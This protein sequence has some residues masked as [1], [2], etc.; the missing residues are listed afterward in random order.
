MVL[1]ILNMHE[2]LNLDAFVMPQCYNTGVAI[3][4]DTCILTVKNSLKVSYH[5]LLV[6]VQNFL[7]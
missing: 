4:K 6:S 7:N 2:D 1:N 3:Y 5:T